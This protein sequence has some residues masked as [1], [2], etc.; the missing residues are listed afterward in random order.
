MEKEAFLDA[1]R[2]YIVIIDI[3]NILYMPLP[4]LLDLMIGD[5]TYTLSISPD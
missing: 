1:L 5:A 4:G 2:N 3:L